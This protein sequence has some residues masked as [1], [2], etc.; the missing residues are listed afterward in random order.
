VRAILI[1]GVPVSRTPIVSAFKEYLECSFAWDVQLVE[2]GRHRS[3]FILSSLRSVFAS[4][5]DQILVFFGLQTLPVL[6]WASHAYGNARLVYWAL[7]SYSHHDGRS[8]ALQMARFETLVSWNRVDLVIPVEERRSFYCRKY[9]SVSVVP[10]VPRLGRSKVHR[11]PPSESEPVRMVM[12]G[13]LDRSRTFVSEVAR[14]SSRMAG[15]VLVDFI[16]EPIPAGDIMDRVGSSRFRGSLPHGELV[17]ELQ[18][19]KYHYSIVGYKCVDFNSKFCAPN[20]LF[21]S[22]SLSLPSV[23]H[24][25][26][27]TLWRL[28]RSTGGGR[29]L[30]L[31]NLEDVST[32]QSL[33]ANYE[34]LPGA[35]YSAYTGNLNLEACCARLPWL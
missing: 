19:G 25:G 30:D 3:A 14:W 15:E 11:A 12:F 32:T 5:P 27:P 6:A 16:G 23:C 4:R 8:L 29:L 28:I 34:D 24:R 1:S 35:A 13:A 17:Q 7:E 31:G 10:N 26:N 21:E 20:K 18:S 9:R 2:L 33:R 22:F